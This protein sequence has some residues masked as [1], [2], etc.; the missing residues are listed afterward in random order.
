MQDG[1]YLSIEEA[2]QYLK[3]HYGVCPSAMTVWRWMSPK[4]GVT[5]PDGSQLVLQSRLICKSRLTTAEWIEA[6][7]DARN[8][9]PPQE[10]LNG[11]ASAWRR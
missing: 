4:H 6:F 10:E 3:D 2:R 1:G 9:G 8:A 11:E 7:L 5:A